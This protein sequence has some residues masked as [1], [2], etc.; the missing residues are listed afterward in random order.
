[1]SKD[2]GG[3]AGTKETES[4]HVTIARLV[5]ELDEAKAT[6]GRALATIRKAKMHTE[7][8]ELFQAHHTLA[9]YEFP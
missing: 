8:C 4:P 5:K 3:W 9:Q 1:M 6:A 7:R 2:A